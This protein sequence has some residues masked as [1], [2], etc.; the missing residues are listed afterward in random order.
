MKSINLFTLI[1]LCV[2]QV[3][4]ASTEET[5]GTIDPF[6][7]F[8]NAKPVVLIIKDIDPEVCKQQ[9]DAF[10]E[11]KNLERVKT[12]EYKIVEYY[13][14]SLFR[15]SQGTTCGDPL[16]DIQDWISRPVNGPARFGA[17]AGRILCISMENVAKLFSSRV[18]KLITVS[19]IEQAKTGFDQWQQFKTF[20]E[21]ALKISRYEIEKLSPWI[22]N[23][24]EES[25]ELGLALACVKAG[26]NIREEFRSFCEEYLGQ[27]ER[28]NLKDDFDEFTQGIVDARE[29]SELVYGLPVFQ[30]SY[31]FSVLLAE[32]YRDFLEQ[33]CRG[34]QGDQYRRYEN[35]IIKSLYVDR[36]S[37][38]ADLSNTAIAEASKITIQDRIIYQEAE[39][40]H[41]DDTIW[42]LPPLGELR[43]YPQTKAS[44]L[45]ALQCHGNLYP[46]GGHGQPVACVGHMEVR[47]GKISKI[48]R[49]SGH[50][51][52][53]APQ[54]IFAIKYLHELGV[55]APN[56]MIEDVNA[57]AY[58]THHRILTLQEVL[59]IADMIKIA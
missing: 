33:L 45:G 49:G 43:I 39:I 1:V 46:D 34:S 21:L 50:Y 51:Q 58:S 57:G 37:S 35:F 8:Q 6:E 12:E 19:D 24:G 52:P 31:D 14:A 27:Q 54:L 26:R 3:H 32:P 28:I 25:L 36:N 15:P 41:T 40:L 42:A 9:F 5:T 29:I 30:K 16:C 20:S 38:R 18:E 7:L 47:N 55:I 22:M 2:S 10:H 11:A 53:S 44:M 48:N 59:S 17:Q 4:S 23:A 56:I 13:A